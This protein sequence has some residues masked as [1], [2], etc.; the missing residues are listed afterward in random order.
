MVSWDHQDESGAIFRITATLA[1]ARA[2]G[3]TLPE[4]VAQLKEWFPPYVPPEN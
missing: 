2:N 3:M 1:D 4:W